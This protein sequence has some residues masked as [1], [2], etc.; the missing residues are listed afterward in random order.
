[1]AQIRQ[2]YLD[3][4][5]RRWMR[6]D[7]R[8]FWKP[9]HENDPF[10]K[11]Y[12]RIERKFSPDQP[13]VPAGA[14][15]GGQWTSGSNSQGQTTNDV[16]SRRLGEPSTVLDKRVSAPKIRLAARISPAREEE[17]ELQLRR[18]KFICN[19]VGLR[20]CHAQAAER[21]AACLAGRPIPPLFF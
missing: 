12:E 13:R 10:Y 1:M 18:D 19:T 9:G 11:E 17:C 2:V 15:E 3:H 14:R 7:W 16:S 6:P 5:L 8:R 20:S 21:Y 4:E